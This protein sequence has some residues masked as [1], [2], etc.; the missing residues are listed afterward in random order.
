MGFIY[1]IFVFVATV[2]LSIFALFSKK[3]KLFVDGRKEIFSK[4][5]AVKGENTIWIHA[6]SLG[7][8]EQAI[9]II[10]TLNKE[11]KD[12]KIIVT[13][14]SPSGYEI[15]KNYNLAD[16]VCYMPLDSKANARKFIR[17]V[18]PILA[19]FIKYEFW[20]NFLNELKKKKVPTI[21]VSG[22]LRENQIFFKFYGGFM[23]KSL[24]AFHHFFVQN[25]IS[26][27]L[28]KSIN[29]ENAT[30]SGDTRFD[31]VSKILEQDNALNFIDEFKNNQYTIVAGS[32]WQEDEELLVNYINNNTSEN[33]KFIIAP[34]TINQ[35]AILALQKSIHKKTVL[36]SA[37]AHENLA[38]CQVFIIDTIGIL[39]KIYATADVAYVGGGLKT[40]LHNILEP[41]TFGIPV[42]IG[43]RYTKFKEAVD[44]VKLKGCISISNQKEFLCIFDK[45]KTDENYRKSTGKI[46]QK[47]IQE[48]FG[49]TKIIMNYLKDKI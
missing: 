43:N 17:E 30:I 44:L 41:A 35:E 20:P 34:H 48:N 10:E 16:V 18:N 42:V 45:L 19:I 21:L 46:N 4:I 6:A 40:G 26:K 23:R 25:Q 29:F 31:R 7:E 22:I 9:P 49:A 8:F 12:Y 28:L 15:R 36:F 33:E 14:F 5:T 47:Y 13:F 32:T 11:Y 3:L 37:K 2:L 1:N 24:Q 39:T 27:E 38:E